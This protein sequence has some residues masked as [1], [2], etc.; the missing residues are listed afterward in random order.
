MKTEDL[1]KV[2]QLTVWVNSFEISAFEKPNLASIEIVEKFEAF[3]K[4]A[5]NKVNE[6]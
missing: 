4:W 5:L 3:K 6:A 2:N 1:V